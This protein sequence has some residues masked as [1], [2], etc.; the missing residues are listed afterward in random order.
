MNAI[1]SNEKYQ[2]LTNANCKE[3]YNFVVLYLKNDRSQQ[4]K[5]PIIVEKMIAPKDL[6]LELHYLYLY[7]T[8]CAL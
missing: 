5:C 2:M 8:I 3:N 7:F 1:I 6:G 4:V